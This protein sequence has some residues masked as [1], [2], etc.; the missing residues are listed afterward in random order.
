MQNCKKTSNDRQTLIYG[1]TGYTG[2]LVSEQA[3]Q[4]GLDFIVAG[5]DADKVWTLAGTLGAPHRVFS[6]DNA[7]ELRSALGGC[8]VILRRAV[9]PNR[10]IMNACIDTGCTI[11]TSRRNSMSTRLRQRPRSPNVTAAGLFL[12][13]A[14]F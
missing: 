14:S 7:M 6:I 13:G 2:Q 5:R 10:P 12:R 8:A 11:R 3:K 1:A 9:C 4:A